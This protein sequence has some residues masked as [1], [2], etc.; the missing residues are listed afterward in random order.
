MIICNCNAISDKDFKK[1]AHYADGSIK[2]CFSALDKRP[3]C[4]RCFTG[5]QNIIDLAHADYIAAE[6]LKKSVA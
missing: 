4:G 3:N 2:K 6:K 5:I 1:V